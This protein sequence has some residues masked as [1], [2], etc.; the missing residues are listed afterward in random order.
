[1]TKKTFKK[2]Y[3]ELYLINPEVYDKIIDNISDDGEKTEMTELNKDGNIPSEIAVGEVE[4]QPINNKT[5]ENSFNEHENVLSKI[6]EI[7]EI[8][9]NKN[10]N[11]STQETQ[12]SNDTQTPNDVVSFSENRPQT[13]APIPQSTYPPTQTSDDVASFSEN[14]PQTD[15]PIS[16]FTYTPNESAESADL[17]TRQEGI[18]HVSESNKKPIRKKQ[19]Y[20]TDCDKLFST[21]FNMKRHIIKL[22]TASKKSKSSTNTPNKRENTLIKNNLINGDISPSSNSENQFFGKR[23]R[24]DDHYNMNVKKFRNDQFSG[25]RKRE[26]QNEIRKKFFRRWT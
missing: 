10:Q 9:Q 19:F 16:Q 5:S 24:I 6:N 14:R 21:K 23:K 26:H 22:H 25:K 13:N 7:K 12:T 20:C 17:D 1:M 15:A 2:T 3:T 4:T 8:I 18:A 11:L